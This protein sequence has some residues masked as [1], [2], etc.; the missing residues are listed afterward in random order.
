[1][2]D[3]RTSSSRDFAIPGKLGRS[4][5]E[6]DK[7]SGA[8]IGSLCASW[9]TDFLS[10]IEIIEEQTGNLDPKANFS[11]II[12][13]TELERVKFLVRS[14]LRI[15]LQKV[16]LSVLSHSATILTIFLYQYIA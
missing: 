4:N 9:H 14:Y 12:I 1:M 5:H 8:L 15:R 11:L 13:Q 6:Q 2:V 10:Q 16:L 3:N 7:T